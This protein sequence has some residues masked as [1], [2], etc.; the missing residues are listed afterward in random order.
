MEIGEVDAR[1][2]RPVERLDVGGELDQIAGDEARREAEVAQQLDEQ[3]A[4]VA[5]R[6]GAARERHVGRLDAGLEPDD[7]ADVA[8]EAL[9]EADQEVEGARLA[10]RDRGQQ[11]LE[12]RS[13]RGRRHEGCQITRQRRIVG[14]RPLLGLRL[15]EKVE[16]VDDRDLGDEVDLDRE[17]A[18]R[19][20][21]DHPGQVVAVRILEP[22]QEVR[23]R[24]HPQGIAQDR[25]PAVR[26]RAQP[27]GLRRQR[28]APVVA[29]IGAVREGDVNGHGAPGCAR[30]SPAAS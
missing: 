9:V 11:R 23:L 15:E 30:P 28:D 6:A 10:A 26:R 18:R 24:S 3:P 17:R 21:E 12:P 5:A 4:G 13:G 16:G 20:R 14:E 29:V 1:P 22:V 2:G 25:R 8:G 7:V 19:L 27:D